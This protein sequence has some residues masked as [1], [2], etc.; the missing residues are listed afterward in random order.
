MSSIAQR[1]TAGAAAIILILAL[2]QYVLLAASPAEASHAT[3]FPINGAGNL[4]C[5]QLAATFGFDG[6]NEVKVD[7]P[8]AGTRAV[9]GGGEFTIN[10]LTATSFDWTSTI[11]VAAVFV[12]SGS[13]A[14]N[15]YVYSPEAFSDTGLSTRGGKAI[16][17]ISF[18]F[19]D[20][21]SISTT[22]TQAEQTTMTQA[23][24]TTTTSSGA[25]TT[26]TTSSFATTTTSSSG[27]TTRVQ[28]STTTSAI[29]GAI[30]DLVWL[31]T[32]GN[33][34][35][36]GGGEIPVANAKVEL[37]S[38]DGVVLET[39]VTGPDGLYLF[40]QLEAGIYRVKVCVEGAEYT[41][42]NAAGVSDSMDSDVTGVAT[43]NAGC[44][45]TTL[46][47]LPAGVT[48]LTWDAGIAADVRGI[49]IETTTTIEPVTVGSLPFTGFGAHDALLAGLIALFSGSVILLLGRLRGSVDPVADR[50]EGW[51]NG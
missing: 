3:V 6:S 29:L 24:Q 28:N 19:S 33:G 37:L 44:G 41:I 48:D 45:E 11:G 50:F 5:S 9:P 13:D 32:D 38:V 27:P 26:T 36:D 40:D 23:E 49:Q 43:P 35:Q 51:S 15:L 22:T 31:D 25:T 7:P 39:Q 2:M 12:K 21:P 42:T 14:S 1:R 46:I 18:C 10:N 30:G 8:V 4:T 34:R 16:S 47:D 20:S 17:H